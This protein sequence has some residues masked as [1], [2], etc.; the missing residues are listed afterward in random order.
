LGKALGL[1]FAVRIRTNSPVLRAPCAGALLT[2]LTLAGNQP[3]GS[4]ISQA[5]A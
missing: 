4:R 1:S 3:N 2:N 5:A